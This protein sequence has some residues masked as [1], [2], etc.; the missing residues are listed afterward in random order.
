MT[1]RIKAHMFLGAITRLAVECGL[2]LL[3]ADVPSEQALA[4]PLDAPVSL[5]IEPGG[6][7]LMA[8]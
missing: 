8:P 7:R 5:Q 4:I 3:L 2:G 6:V 1:G